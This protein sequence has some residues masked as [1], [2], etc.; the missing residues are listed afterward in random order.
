MTSPL[1]IGSTLHLSGPQQIFFLS[2]FVW[3]DEEKQR[4]D[5]FQHCIQKRKETCGGSCHTAG[6]YDKKGR[7]ASFL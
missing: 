4:I 5:T 7:L 3:I 2:E 6:L 1:N